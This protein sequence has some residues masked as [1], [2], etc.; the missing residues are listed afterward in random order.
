MKTIIIAGG[1]CFLGQV[2]ESYF[3]DKV[4]SLKSLQGIQKN[5]TRYFGMQ[6]N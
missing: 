6:K 1:S 4:I 5:Q 2:L 3:Q